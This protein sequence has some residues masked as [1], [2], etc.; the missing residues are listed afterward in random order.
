MITITL[1][2]VVALRDA[3]ARETRASVVETEI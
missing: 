1:L 2:D 3:R